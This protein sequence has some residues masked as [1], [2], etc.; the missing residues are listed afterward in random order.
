[1]SAVYLQLHFSPGFV[2]YLRQLK[3]AEGFQARV[4]LHVPGG[5][6][7][8]REAPPAPSMNG[9]AHPHLHVGAFDEKC[10]KCGESMFASIHDAGDRL[11]TRRRAE[12]EHAIEMGRASEAR[13]REW[14][15]CRQELWAI[16]V[17]LLPLARATYESASKDLARFDAET[18]R[19]LED[20]DGRKRSLIGQA[21]HARATRASA[22]SPASEAEVERL[23][24]DARVAGETSDDIL[25]RRLAERRE[26][27]AVA[28]AAAREYLEI[29]QRK[30]ALQASD[31]VGLTQLIEAGKRAQAELET[32]PVQ[33]A[34]ER[35]QP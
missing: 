11:R 13:E 12:L 19:L 27:A 35:G 2:A 8:H 14:E 34:P 6:D 18:E 30:L 24:S 16:V 26:P 3:G 25:R 17:E 22:S 33:S 32:L 23:E 20:A 10:S 15:R 31:R 1:M 4:N 21:I 7:V 28:R 9:A 5:H 29:G